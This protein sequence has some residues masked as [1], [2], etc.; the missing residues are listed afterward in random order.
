MCKFQKGILIT[1]A[2]ITATLS[3]S[4][5]AQDTVAV[6]TTETTDRGA[7]YK[8]MG[9]NFGITF[10]VPSEVNDLITDIFNEIKSGYLVQSQ[11]GEPSM[12]MGESFK[13]KGVFYLNRH[14]ALEP[15][16]QVFWAAKWIFVTG[17][18]D[19][20]EWVHVLFYSG[21]VNAWARFK[22]DKL[23][24]FKAGLGGFGGF[25]TLIATG[26]VGEVTLSGAGYGGNVLAGIDLT[27]GKAAVNLD[28][29][30]PVGVIN[31]TSRKG[32]LSLDADNTTYPSRIL[33]VGFEF[34]PGV[35]FR[36]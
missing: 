17:G 2:L 27:F 1:V 15:Y 13:L 33:L 19:L 11:F 36:F 14:I 22:P 32:S 16:A 20:S 23:V 34:R 35:T 6:E 4:L 29:S 8:G 10:F 3:F 31:Y 25:S 7:A 28:F 12:F 26:D 30:V 21:G 24:S 9:L 18:A 5:A